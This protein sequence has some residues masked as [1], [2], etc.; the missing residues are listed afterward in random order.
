MN[1]TK[2]VAQTPEV[3]LI[4]ACARVQRSARDDER[5]RSLARESLDW[6][7]VVD[8]AQDHCVVPLLYA[9]LRAAAPAEVPAATMSALQ[10]QAVRSAGRSL[11]LAA[12][13][14]RLLAQLEAR[15]IPAVPYKGPLLAAQVYGN[16]TLRQPGDLDILIRRQDFP[17]ARDVLT[18]HGF[19]PSQEHSPAEERRY[20]QTHHEYQFMREDDQV[21]VELQWE[22]S[23]LAFPFPLGYDGVRD[24]LVRVD[25]AGVTVPCIAV[26]Q[27]LIILAV[28]GSKHVWNRLQ[29]ICDIAEIVRRNPSIDWPRL[30]REAGALGAGRMLAL[31]LLLART[32]LDASVPAEALRR[33]EA[34]GQARMLS[35]RLSAAL[36]HAEAGTD[37]IL[38]NPSLYYLELME[39]LR[40]RLRLGVH[41]FRRTAQP[42]QVM[43]E[44]GAGA[45]KR[46][47]GMECRRT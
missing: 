37:R 22:L 14:A 45:L 46:T 13:L 2:Q 44:Y 36:L 9:S 20:A 42:I 1:E 11:Y 6:A 39:R 47:L 19:R 15:G 23:R 3:Q 21:S 5:I 7:S 33:V 24:R 28:H 30:F 43:R 35:D 31:G 16:I 32:L 38:G 25:L 12:E 4:L 17:R 10:Y 40:D 18:A 41:F 26:E 8:R 29:W 34:D 27:Q